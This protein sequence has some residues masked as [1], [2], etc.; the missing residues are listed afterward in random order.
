MDTGHLR[1]CVL[2]FPNA[3]SL[4]RRRRSTTK[5][6]TQTKP[7]HSVP[8]FPSIPTRFLGQSV[9]ASRPPIV[10]SRR[11]HGEIPASSCICLTTKGTLV[12]L[13]VAFLEIDR[14]ELNIVQIKLSIKSRQEFFLCIVFYRASWVQ[15]K[16]AQFRIYFFR[17][18]SS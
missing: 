17:D 10:I 3:F 12:N 6:E 15:K 5:T 1:R 16:T 11:F 8:M 7:D 14:Y 2:A 9:Y 4:G 18:C 13:T